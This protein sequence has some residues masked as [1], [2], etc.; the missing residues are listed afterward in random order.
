MK[1]FAL[2]VA[3]ILVAFSVT[4]TEPAPPPLHGW[5]DMHTHP[6]AHLAFGG[7]LLHGAP[8][9]NILMSAIP[10]GDG[11]HHYIPAGNRTQASQ[12][13]RSIH[14]GW[15]F[16]NTC[17]DILRRE[18][19]NRLA[20]FRLARHPVRNLTATGFRHRDASPSGQQSG[21]V[22]D[23]LVAQL[24]RDVPGIRAEAQHRPDAEV[25]LA[26][27][28]ADHGVTGFT[29]VGMGVDDR[30]HHRLASEAHPCRCGWCLDL[31]GAADLRDPR[32][33]D[34]ERPILDRRAA[35]ADDHPRSFVDGRPS[36]L[37]LTV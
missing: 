26:L 34:D 36:R 15:W 10:S 12:E 19:L 20:R 27:Q 4:A 18:F 8:D 9:L 1:P 11:C 31:A 2:V 23:A 22:R 32:A 33:L 30:R 7:K 13:D 6:M 37:G 28:K 21:P 16:N 29:H 35:V 3:S 24:E 5:V 17:G 14:G 25:G